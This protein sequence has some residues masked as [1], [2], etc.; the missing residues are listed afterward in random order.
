MV[1]L[2]ITLKLI[3]DLQNISRRI[4]GNFLIDITPTN[5]F[6]TLLLLAKYHLNCEVALGD[7]VFVG[8]P[9]ND[10]SSQKQPDILVKS[11]T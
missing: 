9:S 6:L 2:A 3:M 4:V 8:Q 5:I 10:H 11:F 7:C 1:L